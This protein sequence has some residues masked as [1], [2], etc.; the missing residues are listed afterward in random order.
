MSLEIS[1]KAFSRSGEQGL[2]NEAPV[3]RGVQSFNP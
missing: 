1:K 2:L 3:P